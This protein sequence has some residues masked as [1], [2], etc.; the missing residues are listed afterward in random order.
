MGIELKEIISQKDMTELMDRAFSDLRADYELSIDVSREKICQLAETNVDVDNHLQNLIA[1]STHSSGIVS[2][3]RGTGKTHLMLLARNAI[4]EKLLGSSGNGAFCVYLNAKRFTMPVGEQSE[5]LF[6]RAFSLFL[7]DAFALQLK[8]LLEELA[9]RL[10][11]ETLKEKLLNFL[12]SGNKQKLAESMEAAVKKLLEFKAIVRKG[13]EEL[14]GLSAGLVTEESFEKALND[15][16][17]LVA[18]THVSN[19]L[20]N[21]ND[22]KIG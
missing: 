15:K 11:E 21:E 17:R 6:N 16:T 14:R 13:T 18:M 7:Y 10:E 19:V 2:G 8:A 22:I 1:Y 3:L 12:F 9:K 5:E 4:N 20:G